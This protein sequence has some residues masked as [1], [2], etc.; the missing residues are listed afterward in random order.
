M[1]HDETIDEWFVRGLGNEL[2]GELFDIVVGIDDKVVITFNHPSG[3]GA[4]LL[5]PEKDCHALVGEVLVRVE[6]VYL[7]QVLKMAL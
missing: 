6:D 3:I 4:E 2:F 7:D 5:D 1:W